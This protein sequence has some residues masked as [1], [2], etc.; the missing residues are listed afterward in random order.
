MNRVSKMRRNMLKDFK[1]CNLDLEFAGMLAI[2][3]MAIL[4]FWIIAV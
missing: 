2:L 4:F 1:E 3:L